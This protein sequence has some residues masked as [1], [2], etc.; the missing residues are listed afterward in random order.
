MSGN[1][2]KIITPDTIPFIGISFALMYWI[3]DSL[4]DVYLYN[5]SLS[6]YESI[7]FPNALQ[8][9]MRGFVLLLF[10]LFSVYVRRMLERQEQMEERMQHYEERFEYL[11]DD[12]RMEMSERKQAILDLEELSSIDELT[13]ALNRRKLHEVMR[14]EIDLMYR[15]DTDLSI[16][17]CDIDNFRSINDVYGHHAGDNVLIK[18]TQ[19]ITNGIREADVFARWGGGEFVILMPD[20]HIEEANKIAKQLNKVISAVDFPDAGKI[21]VSFG[22]SLFDSGSDT[23][24][25]FVNRSDNALREEKISNQIPAEE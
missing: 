2:R 14:K 18:L 7:L 11:V 21:T 8:L 15:N 24:D 16:V 19:V 1:K 5:L 25:T 12:L 6:L 10:M 3:T 17:M 22:A 9:W 23:A 4:I 13:A 20:T